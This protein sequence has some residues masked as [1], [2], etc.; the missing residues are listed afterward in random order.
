M[1]YISYFEMEYL[2]CRKCSSEGAIE[3]N[4]NTNADILTDTLQDIKT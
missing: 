3:I 2:K 1:Y 4:I